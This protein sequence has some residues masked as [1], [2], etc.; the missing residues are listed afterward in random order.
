M[1]QA[2]AFD[3]MVSERVH[4]YSS[5]P[6]KALCWK[7]TISVQWRHM[8]SLIKDYGLVPDDTV[9]KNSGVLLSIEHLGTNLS[10]F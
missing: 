4:S 7:T 8:A 6:D 3:F 1:D 9:T 5:A 10:D 2:K